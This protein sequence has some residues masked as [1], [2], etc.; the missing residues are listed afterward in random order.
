[1]IYEK[2]KKTISNAI[3]AMGQT[4]AGIRKDYRKELWVKVQKGNL[5]DAGN[6]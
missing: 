2:T 5:E 4:K 3:A 6:A 1:M